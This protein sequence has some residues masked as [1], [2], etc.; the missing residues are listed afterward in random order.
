[1]NND[2][3]G[4][5]GVGQASSA[6]LEPHALKVGVSEHIVEREPTLSPLSHTVCRH[7]YIWT[8]VSGNKAGRDSPQS[9]TLVERHLEKS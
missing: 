3:G 5:L 4:G 8:R 9:W 6:H 2:G 7:L 1:M